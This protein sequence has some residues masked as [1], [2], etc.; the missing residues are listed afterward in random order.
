MSQSNPQH[1]PRRNFLRGLLRGRI[2]KAVA[3]IVLIAAIGVYWSS[4][5]EDNTT[6]TTFAARRGGLLISVT[7]GGNVEA[8]ESQV[9]KSEIKGETKIL[10]IVDEGYLVTPEDVANGKV[11]VTLDDSDLI[12]RM[13]QETI[14]FQ[15]AYANFTDA[16]EQYEIQ[17][18]QNESDI[19]AAA[20]EVKFFL[21]DFRKYLG[22]ELANRIVSQLALEVNVEKMIEETK[23]DALARISTDGATETPATEAPAPETTIEL[24]EGATSEELKGGDLPSEASPELLAKAEVPAEKKPGPEKAAA[25]KADMPNG[26]TLSAEPSPKRPSIDFTEYASP[27]LL[28]DGEAQ[29]KL[30][31]LQ[32]ER[33][34]S[35][36]ELQLAEV[37]LAGTRRLAEK[38]FVTKQELDGDEM[39]VK[40]TVISRDSAMTD[41][42]LFIK[43]EFPK[44]SEKLLSDYEEAIRKLERTI[45]KGIA[46]EAQAEARWKSSEANFKLREQRTK[47]LQE[48]LDSC[49]IRA[50]RTGLV[51]Y[52]GSDE[53][54]RNREAIE[55][56]ASVYERQEIITI[57]DMTQMAVK[58]KIHES[59]IKKIMK[60]QKARI[61]L[62][63]YLEKEL[64]G[65]VIKVNVIPDSSSR[66]MN[67]DMKLYPA[68]VTIDGTHDWLKP[69]MSAKVEILVKQLENVIYVPIQAISSDGGLR[70]CYVIDSLGRQ[71]RR[72]V[73]T[74]EFN[75]EFIEVKSGLQEG[76][77]VLLRA[78]Q[79][80]LTPAKDGGK[81]QGGQ[82]KEGGEKPAGE[83][84][85]PEGGENK[86]PQPQ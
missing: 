36:E 8:L 21:M 62:D 52:A 26:L 15:S 60:G 51:V 19:T 64:T 5:G 18:K 23:R 66:W 85:S 61:K 42:E 22:D 14:E 58:V 69:G 37:K 4:G 31:Q 49:T 6:R 32:S 10:T 30:R 16:R 7:E 29:Q 41:E 28:G 24:P 33:L 9:I 67:P 43:Y 38:N 81:E 53:P 1:K 75:N 17:V 63:S 44:Q 72:V 20:L 12:E 77:Q 76:E 25:P 71:Q 68:T 11:L 57:P 82:K 40:K 39:S 86:G 54:W 34:I 48:Q 46:T 73:E 35:E 2:R 65:E 80:Q 56:G 59:S 3:L 79:G 70:V 27:D 13:T 50:E 78:P 55:E 74:G 47:E 84:P 83:R 45:K